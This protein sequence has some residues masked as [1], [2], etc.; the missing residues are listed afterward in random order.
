MGIFSK[1]DILISVAT[2][3]IEY[4]VLVSAFILAIMRYAI[5]AVKDEDE[6]HSQNTPIVF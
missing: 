5:M 3:V 4:G 2:S 6:Q 1:A